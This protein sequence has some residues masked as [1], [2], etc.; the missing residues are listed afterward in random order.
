MAISAL[1]FPVY[2]PAMRIVTN[3]TKAF[4]AS[5][6][7]SFAHGYISGTIVRLDV[8][9]GFGMTQVN[10]KFGAI[11]VTSPTTFNIDIDTTQFD[12]FAAPANW[13]YNQQLAQSIPIGEINEILTAAV[14]NVL[15]Y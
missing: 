2:K 5:V 6:T 13:P 11:I 8:P 10:Q 3:I 14:Q 4:P 1:Q 7:T 12:T 9:V 15:P